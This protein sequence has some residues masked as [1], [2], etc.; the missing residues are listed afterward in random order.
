M[1]LEFGFGS[2]AVLD[3]CYFEVIFNQTKP[4]IGTALTAHE[5]LLYS[6]NCRASTHFGYNPL[7]KQFL[8]L[9]RA[10]AYFLKACY[11]I[12]TPIAPMKGNLFP[13]LLDSGMTF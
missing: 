3:L 7:S 13:F 2:Q 5:R 4:R 12:L 11:G 1:E 6:V 8:V 10:R 9:C